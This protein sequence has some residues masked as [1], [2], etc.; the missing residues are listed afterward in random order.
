MIDPFTGTLPM[1][2]LIDALVAPVEFQTNFEVSP[3]KMVAGSAFM[4]I[5]GLTANIGR[6]VINRI[7]MNNLILSFFM[8]ASMIKTNTH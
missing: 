8:L 1:P 4:L 2:W 5:V 6:T 7:V 3:L